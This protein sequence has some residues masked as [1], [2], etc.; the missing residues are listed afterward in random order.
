MCGCCSRQ[1]D[2]C[3]AMKPRWASLSLPAEFAN[4]Y[5]DKT[6][7]EMLYREL[8]LHHANVKSV[9]GRLHLRCIEAGNELSNLL[10]THTQHWWPIVED[11]FTSTAVRNLLASLQLTFEAASEYTCISIDAT[12]KVA[13]CIKGQGNYRA[14]AAVRN[15]A[16]FGDDE[17]LRR[18]LNCEGSNRGSACNPAD[19]RRR[20]Q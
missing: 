19:Q 5:Y 8:V 11:V 18:V 13:M 4:V 15:D 20:C 16:C 2:Q 3:T 6:F 17:A 1:P 7:A 9:W 14:S 12:L 10:P